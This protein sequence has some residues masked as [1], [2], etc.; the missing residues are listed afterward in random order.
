MDGQNGRIMRV[1]SL[2]ILEKTNMMKLIETLDDYFEIS[3][4]RR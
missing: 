2:L 1:R 4:V 3:G